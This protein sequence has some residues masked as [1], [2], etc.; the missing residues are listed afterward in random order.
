M[1]RARSDSKR[2][3][4]ETDDA[5]AVVAVIEP[6]TLLRVQADT[7]TVA[8]APESL[9]TVVPNL[10]AAQ[11]NPD[12]RYGKSGNE[13]VMIVHR[14]VSSR[15]PP[16]FV[17]GRRTA[18]PSRSTLVALVLPLLVFRFYIPN[19]AYIAATDLRPALNPAQ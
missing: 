7:P 10:P 3:L 8:V 2:G 9:T 18:P 14:N 15:V 4:H 13:I 16:R 1:A 6:A 19:G 12:I 5:A 17:P 11:R